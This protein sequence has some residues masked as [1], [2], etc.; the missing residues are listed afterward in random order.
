MQR[1][2]PAKNGFALMAIYLV[3]LLAVNV[4]SQTADTVDK[5]EASKPSVY[6]PNSGFRLVT[7]DMGEVNFRIFSYI[8]YLNQLGLDTSYTDSFGDTKSI[9]RRQ[10]VQLNKVNISFMGWLMDPKFRYLFYVWTNNT[11][12]GQTAQVVVAGNL[13]YTFSKHLTLGG[14]VNSLPGVRST[15]GNF[16]FWLT[17]DNRTISDEFFRPSY[18]MGFWATGAIVDGLRYNVMLGNNL[19]QLGVDAGQLDDNFS[20]FSGALTWF[21][22][23]GEYGKRAQFGDFDSHD[24]VATRLG[25]HFTRSPED[26]QGVPSSEA[27]ENVT[28]RLSDGSVIFAPNLF[29]NGIQI[30]NATYHMSSF[31][32]GIKYKGFSLEGEYYVRWVNDISGRGTENLSFTELKDNGF[33]LMASSMVLP[34]MMQLYA[35]CGKVFGE[36]GDPWEVRGGLNLFPWENQVVRCNLEYIHTYKSPVGGLSLPYQVGGTGDIV[37]F[38]FMVDF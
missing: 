25:V 29:G 36:Y 6:T 2:L 22:T 20:T 13:T 8:R 10:D 7:T 17:V 16:P 18:T 3:L 24:E 11:A 15:E 28:I 1:V 30:Y 34:K 21:P 12:Q 19:S 26:R 14:G 4:R 32:A 5:T 37:H 23:T 35:I 33:Q 31:D 9:D 27:F 38:N